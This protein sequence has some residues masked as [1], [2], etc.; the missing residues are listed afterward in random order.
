M[1]PT[2][3]NP[4]SSTQP[5]GGQPLPP[6][7]TP[8]WQKQA[9]AAAVQNQPDPAEKPVVPAGQPTAWQLPPD[10][11][12]KTP[13]PPAPQH[14]NT[15]PHDMLASVDPV[16]AVHGPS[17][18][19]SVHDPWPPVAPGA[20]VMPGSSPAPAA[21]MPSYG[22]QPSAPGMV[23]GGGPS[24]PGV[25]GSMPMNAG[26]PSMPG[27]GSPM[28]PAPH[29]N[30]KM[31]III[32]AVVGLLVVLPIIIYFVFFSGDKGSTGSKNSAATTAQQSVNASKEKG[33]DLA[34]VSQVTLTAPSD[35]SAYQAPVSLLSTYW[36]YLT[37]DSA[38]SLE[39]G[40]VPT[41]YTELKGSTLQA[42]VDFNVQYLRSLGIT[43]EDP[44]AG[45]ALVIKD[46]KDSSK[47]YKLPTLT[48][49]ISNPNGA[50][51]IS[52]YSVAVT[53]NGD[54]VVI[55]RACGNSSGVVSDSALTSLNDTAKKITVT[56]Q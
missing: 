29:K 9:V 55:A 19:A 38:C 5:S 7:P 4:M 40:S 2:T 8:D 34:T 31:L 33:V 17:S 41:T 24:G 27:M 21:S 16:P 20:S 48:F 23:V 54:R 6:P 18:P 44:T 3:P 50:T 53:K 35:M 12:A 43:V 56:A 39:F 1:D 30:N 32:L 46:S 11:A 13:E 51:A 15:E 26:N 52:L 47:T 42:V 49:K 10:P 45:E 28:S 22:P 37:K 25:S 14:V 36:R